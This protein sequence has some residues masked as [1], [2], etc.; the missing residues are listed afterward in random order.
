MNHMQGSESGSQSIM[1]AKIAKL[2]EARLAS[3]P[4]KNA[5]FKVDVET[6]VLI[7]AFCQGRSDLPL[8]MEI[9]T[10]LCAPK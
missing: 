8:E 2:L 4:K 10:V 6:W 1:W 9:R 7:E 3:G 5:L